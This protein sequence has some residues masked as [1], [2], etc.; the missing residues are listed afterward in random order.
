MDA[1]VIV[2]GAGLAGLRCA[3]V[4]AERGVDVRVLEAGDEVGGRVRTDVVEG[5]RCDRGFQVVNPSYPAVRRA[6]DLDALDLRPFGRGIAVR[7]DTGL[8]ELVDP[9]RKPW[10][11]PHMLR[12]GLVR[13]LEVARLGAWLA[14]ALGPVP[15]LL[16]A[17]D[18]AWGESLDRAG[19]DGPLRRE[20]LERFLAGVILEEDGS[21]SVTFVRLLLRSFVLGTPGVPAR[22]MGAI[23]AQLAAPLHDR[24]TTGVRVRAVSPGRVDTDGANL[25]ARAVV[26]ATDPRTA[27]ELLSDR[28]SVPPMKGLVTD[29]FAAEEAPAT[30]LLR[31]DA[32]RTRGP[33]VN[34]AVVSNAAPTY[35]P[36]GAHLVQATSLL[37]GSGEAPDHDSVRR[38]V[39]DLWEGGLR[40]VRPLVRHVVR[41]AL[42]VQPP[43]LDARRD[44][45][46]GDGLFVCGDHRDTASIQGALISGARAAH[47]VGDLLGTKDDR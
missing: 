19:V 1:D 16:R 46:V 10:R 7:R 27:G 35:A 40:G 45:G 44:I 6:L 28:M 24:V 21:T 14:P 41:D 20:V 34:T 2:V 13:P 36:A 32:R 11:T 29:W 37:G 4:L 31:V 15:R 22:G 3:R 17:R 9:S 30:D 43:P 47:A 26:V 39:E 42:P 33:V 18:L 12:S 5:F 38:Q 25:T 23:A 8:A